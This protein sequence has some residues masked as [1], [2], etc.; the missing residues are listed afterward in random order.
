MTTTPEMSDPAPPGAPLY[1]P[2]PTAAPKTTN[3]LA[4]AGLIV[5][6]I[7]PLIGLILSIFGLVQA[8]KRNQKGRGLAIAGIVVA[9]IASIVYSVAIAKVVGNVATLA[10]PGCTTGKAA[11]LDNQTKA[12]DPATMKDGLQ[13][14]IKGLNDGAA[15]ARNADVRNAMKALSDDYTK[16]LTGLDTG[17]ADPGLLAKIS[18]D[19]EQ[20]DKLCTVGAK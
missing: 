10:D 13:A 11:I 2:A 8:K 7:A 4:I 3:G 6:F 1:P 17:N 9:I 15:K 19:A 20:I 18:Q 5:A 16:L 14:T 12:S